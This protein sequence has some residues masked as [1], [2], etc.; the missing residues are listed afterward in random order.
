MCGRLFRE[1]LYSKYTYLFSHVNVCCTEPVLDAGGLPAQPKLVG[2]PSLHTTG[3]HRP[4]SH[5]SMA[6]ERELNLLGL[7][8]QQGAMQREDVKNLENRE[9][10]QTS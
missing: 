7:A 3:S 5:T 2:G 9:I 4:R 8:R 10:E 1:G 6:I